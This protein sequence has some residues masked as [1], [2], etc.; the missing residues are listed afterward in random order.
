MNV[1]NGNE[2][3]EEDEVNMHINLNGNVMN[4]NNIIHGRQL[5]GAVS[6]MRGSTRGS[7]TRTHPKGTDSDWWGSANNDG[8]D[9]IILHT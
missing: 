6:S 2:H 4:N 8:T 5:S 7:R 9:N 3:E 1:N